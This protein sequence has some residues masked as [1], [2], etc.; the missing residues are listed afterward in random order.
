V[1]NTNLHVS[2]GWQTAAAAAAGAQEPTKTRTPPVSQSSLVPTTRSDSFGTDRT[3]RRSLARETH[4]SGADVEDVE[5]TFPRV[6]A[7]DPT[8]PPTRFRN[9]LSSLRHTRSDHYSY[10]G[11]TV[12]PSASPPFLMASRFAARTHPDAGAPR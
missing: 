11:L 5:D 10:P 4:D 1:R 9:R 3:R 12:S 6:I 7:H 8:Y 2:C